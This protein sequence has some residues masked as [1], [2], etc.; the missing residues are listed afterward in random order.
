M[1]HTALMEL[2]LIVVIAGFAVVGLVKGARSRRSR[3]YAHRGR[4]QDAGTEP[5]YYVD[6]GGSHHHHGHSHDSSG[7][8]SGDSYSDGGGDSGGGDG[9]GGGD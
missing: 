9:G 1:P 8:H 3:G 7:H 6:N 4:P 5:T 2:L